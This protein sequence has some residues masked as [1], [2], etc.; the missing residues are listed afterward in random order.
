MGLDCRED[1][2]R[3]SNQVLSAV[4]EFD[5]ESSI[6]VKKCDTFGQPASP[7]V[8]DRASEFPLCRNTCQS[9]SAHERIKSTNNDPFLPEFRAGKMV[10]M[11][12]S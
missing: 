11:L 6:T 8:L 3:Q 5:V 1:E 12:A 9:L 7:A 10:T 2:I 4:S